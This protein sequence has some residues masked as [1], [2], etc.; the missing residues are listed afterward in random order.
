MKTLFLLLFASACFRGGAQSLKKYNIG[1]SGCSLYTYCATKFSMDYSDDSSKV[2]TGECSVGGVSYG[3]ICIKL[4]NQVPDLADAEDLMISYLT[5][6][7]G[8]FNII[9]SAGYGYGHHVKDRE[10]T[11]G[12]IDYW[13]DNTGDQW[14]IKSYTDGKF[15]GFMYAYS[16]QQLPENKVDVFLDSFRLPA[17]K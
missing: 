15:I 11:R 8:S 12:V 2:Y 13:T 7:K 14:K 5:H 6:L 9:K 16:S 17:T 4:L 3:V 1:N 10:D